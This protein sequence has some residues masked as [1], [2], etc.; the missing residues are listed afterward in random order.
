M[1][2]FTK[3]QQN[4]ANYI[5]EKAKKYIVPRDG[6]VHVIM[7]NSFSKLAN[8]SFECETKYTTQLNELITDMQRDGREIVDIKLGVL[9]N[10]GITGQAEGFNTLIMYK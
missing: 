1:G 7:F 6:L 4:T 2:M 8:Q 10:Q 5:Y 3:S 9:Q